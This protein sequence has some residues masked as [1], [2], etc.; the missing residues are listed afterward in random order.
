[1]GGAVVYLPRGVEG[2]TSVISP[3]RAQKN[4]ILVT[5][6]RRALLSEGI[7][8]SRSARA[9]EDFSMMAGS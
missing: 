2:G 9:W 7:K 4:G 1:M 3:Q 5:T 8:A 6:D